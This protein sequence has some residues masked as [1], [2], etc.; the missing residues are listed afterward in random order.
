MLFIVEYRSA[1]L[2]Q[3]AGDRLIISYN[4][5]Y[6]LR[7]YALSIATTAADMN[8]DHSLPHFGVQY[9]SNCKRKLYDVDKISH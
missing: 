3:A 8:K 1:G 7:P 6:L 9:L 5:A 2:T 4:H